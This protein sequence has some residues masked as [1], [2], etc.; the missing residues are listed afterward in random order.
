MLFNIY[1]L[2]RFV[3]TVS[4]ANEA[5]ARGIMLARG[6]YAPNVAEM[7][8]VLVRGQHMPL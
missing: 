4:A 5:E 1:F 6:Y 3:A 8:I 2:K 7:E